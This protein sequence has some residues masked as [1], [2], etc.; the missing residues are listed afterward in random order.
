M[1]K[2]IYFETDSKDIA[3]LRISVFTEDVTENKTVFKGKDGQ[4]SILY[5]KYY[6]INLK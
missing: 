4:T 1:T 6:Y 5:R 3:K 2:Y